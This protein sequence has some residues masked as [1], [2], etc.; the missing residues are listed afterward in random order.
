RTP[1]DSVDLVAEPPRITKF[2]GPAVGARRSLEEASKTSGI[3][4]PVRRQLDKDWAKGL[5]EPARPVEELRDRRVRLLQALQVRTIAAELQ[6]IAEVRRCLLPPCIEALSLWQMVERVVNLHGI[7][8]TGVV[9]KPTLLREMPRVEDLLPVVIVV[10]RSSDPK[11]TS[12]GTHIFVNP[13]H[14][15]APK[16]RGF[17]PTTGATAARN[18]RHAMKAHLISRGHSLRVKEGQNLCQQCLTEVL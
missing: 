13:A 18:G 17:L 9:G 5:S 3:R 6:R 1:Q 2:D 14:P 12:C 8:M 11:L 4:S 15:R 7:E 16:T 10:A